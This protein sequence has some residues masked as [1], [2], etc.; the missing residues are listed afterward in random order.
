MEAS[1][2]VLS[3]LNTSGKARFATFYHSRI[4][5]LLIDEASQAT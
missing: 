1:E 5:C 3:T 2:I 4:R